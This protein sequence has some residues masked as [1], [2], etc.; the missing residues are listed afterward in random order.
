MILVAVEALPA[1]RKSPEAVSVRISTGEK[2]GFGA[3]APLSTKTPSLRERREVQLACRSR[4]NLSDRLGPF[5]QN[6]Y[7]HASL[8]L[9][10]RPPY[11]CESC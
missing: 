5:L 2:H 10:Q 7:S 9:L 11:A 6:S 8:D 4:S 3:E 1:G